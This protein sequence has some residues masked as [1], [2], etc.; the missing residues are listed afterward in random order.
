MERRY[1]IREA[2]PAEYE[3]IGRMIVDA[4]ASL[5][6]MPAVDEQPEYYQRLA[7]VGKRQSNPSISV[8]AAV[9][10]AHLVLGSVDF[11][12]DMRQYGSG[13]SA[14][15]IT[16][17][18]GIRLLAVRPECRGLG[19]GQ[20]LTQFCIERARAL[21]KSRVILHTTRAMKT[22]WAMYEKLGFVR[23]P[24]IDFQ[25]GRLE[26][27]GFARVLSPDESHAR[28]ACAP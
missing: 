19:V 26:V 2:L 22:A 17:A 27:F 12:D 28:G 14:A 24:A 16:D 23:F 11:I 1:L 15:G 4:Y 10:D 18:A 8:F 5:A 25:Q 9:D 21:G 3:N 20:A 13:G 7:D 6:G